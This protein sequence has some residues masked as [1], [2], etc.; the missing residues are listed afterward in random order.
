MRRAMIVTLELDIENGTHLRHRLEPGPATLDAEVLV[1]KR[2]VQPLDNPVE[3]GPPDL[4]GPV[5]D[6]LQMQERLVRVMVGPAAERA[7][8]AEHHDLD[9]G[10]LG[11]EG[12]HH[13][14]VQGVD[15]G[16]RHFG[17]V[18]PALGIALVRV[19][20][21]MHLE[22]CPGSFIRENPEHYAAS[23]RESFTLRP[24]DHGGA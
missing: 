15:R 8:V 12:R 18:Q 5:L 17:S 16:H 14:G 1:Q 6:L 22:A 23:F 19:E 9:P 11:L 21:G 20:G 10:L 3:L 24:T 2:A 4:G 13:V 7:T